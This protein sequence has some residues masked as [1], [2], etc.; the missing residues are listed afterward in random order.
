MKKKY[1]LKNLDLGKEYSP[2]S[3]NPK[4]LIHYHLKKSIPHAVHKARKI[5]GLRHPKL[6]FL[7][8]S[9]LFAYYIFSKPF[10]LEWISKLNGLDYFGIFI[11]GILSTFGFTAPFSVGFLLYSVPESILL[12]TIIGGIGAMFAD[13]LIFKLIRFSFMD[14][15]KDLE[16]NK[17]IRKIENVVKNNKHILIRHYLLYIF[18]GILISTPLPDEIGVSILAGLTTIK[19]LK[20]AIISFILHSIFIFFLLNV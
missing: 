11:S 19:P 4:H 20:L 5:F 2:N 14:E 1:N 7:T 8:F 15:I 9:I 17:V 3:K 10:M 18:A 6:I 12:A 16:K 13:L